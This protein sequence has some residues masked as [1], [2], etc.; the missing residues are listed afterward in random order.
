VSEPKSGSERKRVKLQL[1]GVQA[2]SERGASEPSREASAGSTLPTQVSREPLTTLKVGQLNRFALHGKGSRLLLRYTHPNAQQM[3]LLSGLAFAFFACGLA[4]PFVWP[5]RAPIALFAGAGCAFM[6]LIPASH[7]YNTRTQPRV[8]FD[9][10]RGAVLLGAGKSVRK[11]I[12]LDA[13][14][15]VQLLFAWEHGFEIRTPDR[16]VFPWNSY[17]ILLVLDGRR[18]LVVTGGDLEVMRRLGEGVAEFLDVPLLDHSEQPGKITHYLEHMRGRKNL[19]WSIRK[20]I[21][22]KDRHYS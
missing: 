6:A 15:A 1:P 12:P 21:Q 7:V 17:Q 19:P 4:V 13:V 22:L 3:W 18:E 9:R 2:P 10:K 16:N 14:R 11:K 5:E 20:A 8:L